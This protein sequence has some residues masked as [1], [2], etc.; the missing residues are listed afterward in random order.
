MQAKALQLVI[1]R[2][3]HETFKPRQLAWLMDMAAFIIL[4][5]RRQENSR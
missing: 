1:P 2:K 5:L 3:L 4:V